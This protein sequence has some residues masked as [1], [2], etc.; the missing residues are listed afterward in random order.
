MS[1]AVYPGSL[2]G[3]TFG[4][5]D[6]I[7][8]A[9]KAF[10][11]VI[12]GI[13]NNPKKSYMFS[14]AEREKLA[15]HALSGIKGVTVT[16]Y[17]GLLV[18]FMIEN[19]LQTVVRGIRNGAD[20]DDALTQDT[21]GW[22]Q[23]MAKDIQVFY[24]PSR[25]GQTFTSSTAVK[26][27]LAEQGDVSGMAPLSTIHAVQARMMGQYYYGMTGVSGAGKSTISR[28]FTEIAARR[29]IPL[30]HQDLDK[31]GHAILGE[32]TAPIYQETRRRLKEAFGADI[33][34]ENGF[35]SRKAL[36]QK[37][38]GHPERLQQLNEIMHG[39]VFFRL[40]DTLRG[41]KGLFLIDA[42]LL[43]ET[44]RTPLVNNQMLVV[45]ADKKE[46]A[47]RLQRRDDLTPE[48]ITR[49]MSSQLTTQDKVASIRSAIA[50]TNYGHVNVLKNNSTTT[51]AEYERAFDTMLAHTDI[52]G[53][54]RITG[55]LTGL[56]VPD[57]A[58][59][60]TS[61]RKLYAGD[62]RFYHA[63]SHIVAGL[64]M[65]PDIMPM[66]QDKE[67]F[68]LAWMFHDAVYDSRRSDNEEQSAKLLTDMGTAWGLDAE[69]LTR[70]HR[71]VMVTKH[72][73]VTAET[74][75]EKI[76]VDLDNSILGS[77]TAVFNRY[78]NHV[79]REYGWVSDKDWAAGRGAF[80]Q[81]QQAPYYH[82]PYFQEHYAAQTE[83]NL[84]AGLAK[85]GLSA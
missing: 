2:D 24:A 33:A 3:I 66:V 49:R 12:V 60:Y 56:G 29:H 73:V 35:I 34:D 61:L 39:P 75:D 43:A 64:N 23:L 80:L 48:Q 53:E 72:G 1:S 68:M 59:A 8:T 77:P 11:T 22:T 47:A 15:Q 82:T 19:N 32:E 41:R 20:L 83:R 50:A 7:R 17:S 58:Q 79:R 18:N 38:F 6:S 37:V 70:A 13:G 40:N 65:M 42:A 57:P 51:E 67:A 27:I 54:L 25:P 4:H 45:T 63:L 30:L 5:I 52:Y 76:L 55:F 46:I 21:I 74:P 69:L 9:A 14:L 36:G 84:R 78:E 62:D 81:S 85:L 44:G 28:K 71:L 26:A 31:I 10:G 16:P